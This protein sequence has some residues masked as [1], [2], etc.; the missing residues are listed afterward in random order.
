MVLPTLLNCPMCFS[1]KYI[2]N[3]YISAT[4][5]SLCY[6]YPITG[7]SLWLRKLTKFI[8]NKLRKMK[9][10]N[11]RSL[12]ARHVSNVLV[13]TTHPIFH[14]FKYKIS[15]LYLLQKFNFRIKPEHS[16]IFNYKNR[17]LYFFHFSHFRG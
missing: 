12:A 3:S 4:L 7:L 8:E 14:M 1:V 6:I 17:S 11:L 9:D 10:S 5:R 13:S 2:R 15:S 16:L